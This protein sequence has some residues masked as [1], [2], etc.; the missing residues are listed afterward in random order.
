MLLQ[1]PD[2]GLGVLLFME[3]VPSIARLS[4]IIDYNAN[5]ERIT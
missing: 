3:C 4:E 2:I 5:V 1:N